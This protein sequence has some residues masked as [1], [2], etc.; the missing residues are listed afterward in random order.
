MECMQ[1]GVAS[2]RKAYLTYITDTN[3][4]AAIQMCAPTD[5]LE[6][7]VPCLALQQLIVG[8]PAIVFERC[9][10]NVTNGRGP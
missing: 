1:H 8:D 2:K 7:G 9:S 10:C 3:I 6:E 5:S 4:S